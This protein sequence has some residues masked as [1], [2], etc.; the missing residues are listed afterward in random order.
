VTTDLQRSI[1]TVLRAQAD[2]LPVRPDPYVRFIRVERRHRARR[3][4]RAAGVVVIAG[5]TVVTAGTGVVALPAWVPAIRTDGGWTASS[6][7]L[8]EPTHGSLAR[9]AL[10]LE[11][12]R[13]TVQDIEETEGRWR[14]ADRHGIRF[15]FA[16]DVPALHRRLALVVVPLRLGVLETHAPMWYEGP[17]GAA[18]KEMR[19]GATYGDKLPEIVTYGELRWDSGA[20]LVIAPSDATL[21]IS[22]SATYTA[23]GLVTRTW[24]RLPTAA[25]VAIAQLPGAPA[26][27]AA[28]LH[29]WTER[30][31]TTLASADLWQSIEGDNLPAKVTA[32]ATKD[33]RGVL[34]ADDV[35]DMAI[36]DVLRDCALDPAA[37][38]IR[39]PWAG[40]VASGPSLL[41]MVQP[42]G[43]GT[44]VYG[45]Y[46]DG[47]TIGLRLLVPAGGAESRPYAL[48]IRGDHPTPETT[49]LLVI[50]PADA[51]RAELVIGDHVYPLDL[52]RMG[53]AVTA[54]PLDTP[55]SVRAY[56]S[57]GKLLGQTRVQPS[58]AAYS[59]GLPG[60][61]PATRV[62]S[63]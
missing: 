17:L 10:W 46:L 7:L 16:G 35:V 2:Q 34:P 8:Q 44:L 23:Q 1:A 32:A 6:A 31:E 59:P 25:G 54:L 11:E 41:I 24:E 36:E 52:D 9:D 20:A 19:Q 42:R 45:T 12:M 4:V 5:C 55:A 38:T 61:S 15:V 22:R 30:G 58:T 56:D 49:T 62:A 18:A 63:Q 27:M 26:G 53:A 60:E 37:A 29:V 13:A 39:I 3:R 33:T 43:G 28:M 57:E 51:G 21:R 48:W 50:A 14:V 47:R 40:T